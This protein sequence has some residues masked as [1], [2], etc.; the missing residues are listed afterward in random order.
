MA[1]RRWRHH[2]TGLRGRCP[3]GRRIALPQW[4]ALA[5]RWRPLRPQAA[6]PTANARALGGKY[7]SWGSEPPSD[8]LLATAT[9]W[10][11]ADVDLEVAVA[12]AAG[13]KTCFVGTLTSGRTG[14]FSRDIFLQ[15]SDLDF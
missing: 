9:D 7:A 14:W 8:R 15:V 1:C 5:V 11:P 4:R 13:V 10:V 12:F 3:V 2:R 6:R